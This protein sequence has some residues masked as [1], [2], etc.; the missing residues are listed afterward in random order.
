MSRP[1]QIEFLSRYAAVYDPVVRLMGFPRLW[2]T[3]AEVAA[4]ALGEPTLDV[5]AGTGGAALELA[6]RGARVIGLDLADGMLR[7]AR[8]KHNGANGAA[9]YSTPLYVRMDARHLAFADRSFPLVTCSMALH[10]MA[11]AERQEVLREIH[12]I[13]SERVVFAEYRVPRDS[14]R[15]LL[16]RAAMLYEY[17]ESDDFERFVRHDFAGRLEHAG[18][19]LDTPRDVGMYRIWSCRVRP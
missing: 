19:V 1:S 15:S 8:R 11:E 17:L 4:P 5:C 10:E 6:H 12:R 9:G 13:A 7:R 14:A 2:R 16:F 18:F 3:I